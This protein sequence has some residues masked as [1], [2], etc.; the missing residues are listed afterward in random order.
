MAAWM[1]QFYHLSTSLPQRPPVVGSPGLDHGITITIG[2]DHQGAARS[3]TGGSAYGTMA[4]SNT[5]PCNRLGRRNII[6][7][8]M[9][10]PL[11]NPTARAIDP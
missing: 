4:E 9:F 2:D 5:A 8:A 1:R 7:E 10:A 6:A 11:E 3:A